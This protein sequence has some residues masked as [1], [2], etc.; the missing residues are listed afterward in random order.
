MNPVA[1][2]PQFRNTIGFTARRSGG[3]NCDRAVSRIITYQAAI[4]PVQSVAMVQTRKI[5]KVNTD[6]DVKNGT[7]KRETFSVTANGKTRTIAYN[8]LSF[9]VSNAGKYDKIMAYAFPHQLNTFQLL[10][11]ND[12]KFKTSMNDDIIYD[13]CIVG[14]SGD[15]YFYFQKQSLKGGELG[16]IELKKTTETRLDA[17]I[18]QLNAKRIARPSSISSELSWIKA[19]KKQFKVVNR[20]KDMKAFRE[21]LAPVIYPCYDGGRISQEGEEAGDVNAFGI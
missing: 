8:S 7:E 6:Q 12:G 3:Y 20:R 18:L 1:A 2:Y 10:E 14:I 15:D 21:K 16:S 19:E 5:E 11:G 4:R 17:S 9:E 13:I